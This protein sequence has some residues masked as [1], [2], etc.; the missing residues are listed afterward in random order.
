MATAL[1]PKSAEAQPGPGSER[2]FGLV[3]AGLFLIIGGR[4]LLS[5]ESPH[6]WALAVAAAFAVAAVAAPATLRPLNWLWHKFGLLLHHVMSPLVMGTIFF[7]AVT[8]VALI[9]RLLGKDVL[10]LRRRP[11]LSSYWIARQTPGSAPETMKRQF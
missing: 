2:M 11:D 3:F 9:M 10:G 1:D 7:L 4:P 6:W 5:G 8:P